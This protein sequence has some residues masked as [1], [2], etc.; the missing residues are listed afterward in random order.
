MKLPL[1]QLLGWYGTSSLSYIHK[2][3]TDGEKKKKKER[4]FVI[5][6]NFFFLFWWH[7]TF[8]RQALYHFSHFTSPVLVLG[9]FKIRSH[10]LFAWAGFKHDPSDLCLPSS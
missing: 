7:F 6:V 8:A 3:K 5:T 10:E 2:R 1:F 4:D 9:I